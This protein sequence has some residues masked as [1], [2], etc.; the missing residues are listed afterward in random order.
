M[1]GSDAQE[2][3]DFLER[4]PLDHFPMLPEELLVTLFGSKT[5]QV[6]IAGINLHEQLFGRDAGMRLIFQI[7]ALYV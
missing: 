7:Y 6:H 1:Y 4:Y 2:R 3:G 5:V